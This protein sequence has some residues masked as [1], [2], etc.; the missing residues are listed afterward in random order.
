LGLLK[1]KDIKNPGLSV[2]LER[3]STLK[4]QTRDQGGQH[5]AVNK[6][7]HGSILGLVPQALRK[8]LRAQKKGADA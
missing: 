7:P 3:K 8:H 2:V 5:N 4:V 6:L 1:M